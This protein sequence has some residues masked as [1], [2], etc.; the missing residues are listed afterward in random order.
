MDG[1]DDELPH[2]TEIVL[3]T[4]GEVDIDKEHFQFLKDNFTQEQIINTISEPSTS[5]KSPCLCGF[6]QKIA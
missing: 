4:D 1:N 6:F 5:S 3:I 2:T